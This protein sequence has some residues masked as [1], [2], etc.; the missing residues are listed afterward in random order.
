M[1]TWT[2]RAA[3]PRSTRSFSQWNRWDEF[4]SSNPAVFR[5]EVIRPW[6]RAGLESVIT[7]VPA[8][9]AY[10]DFD[11]FWDSNTSI[12]PQANDQGMSPSEKELPAL[13][14]AIVCLPLPWPHRHEALQTPKGRC[15][16]EASHADR[17]L[18]QTDKAWI[19]ARSPPSSP[20]PSGRSRCV[21]WMG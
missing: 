3:E 14:Y 18:R 7:S 9:T 4:G 20:P 21:L 2:S 12:G 19:Y 17:T 1:P 5:R 6:E 16:T 8:Q 15:R 13:T 11:D 10:S